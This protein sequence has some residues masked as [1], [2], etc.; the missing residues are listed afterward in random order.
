MDE[1]YKIVSEKRAADSTELSEMLLDDE[2]HDQSLKARLR[3]YD[4][5]KLADDVNRVTPLVS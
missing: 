5:E 4:V 3:V 1:R 2:Y